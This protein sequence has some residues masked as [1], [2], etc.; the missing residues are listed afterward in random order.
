MKIGLAL[1]AFLLLFAHGIYG[2]RI[3]GTV[4]DR[5]S[6]MPLAGVVVYN[7]QKNVMAKSDTGGHFTIVAG[8][9]DT[10]L[11]R[12][13]SY[14]TMQQAV[15]FSWGDQAKTF[16]MIPTTVHLKEANVV[17]LT[18]YQQDS[19]SMYS[20]FDHEL[21]KPVLPPPKFVGL[22]CAGCVGWIADKLTGNSKRQKKWKKN[23]EENEH[24]HFIDSRYTITI[25]ANLTPLR[26]TDSI[27]HFM[28]AY[29]MEYQFA[30]Q[31][32]DLEMKAWIRTNYREYKSNGFRKPENEKAEE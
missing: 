29:P 18:K 26:D 23:F 13:A 9:G 31:A 12:H 7:Q 2:Q 8:G 16:L 17:G 3:E 24:R 15:V 14:M 32:S 10:I 25:V 6:L 20:T 5:E 11:L 1:A 19:L 28:Q 27:A 21:Q 22:G 30:R 4:L